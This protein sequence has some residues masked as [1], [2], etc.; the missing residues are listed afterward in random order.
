MNRR[1]KDPVCGMEVDPHDHALVYLQMH[2]AFC[3]LQCRERFLANPHLY[4]GIPGHPSPKQ[5]GME[6]VKRRHLRVAKP[7]SSDA[8]AM[9]VEALQTMMG[10]RAVHAE[11]DRVEIAYDLLQVT[12]EQIETKMAEVGVRLGEGWA[13]RLRRAFVNFEEETQVGSLT[14]NGKHCGK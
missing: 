7:L 14:G 2:F 8:A 12:H 3:S 5:E 9:L 13:E 4:V 10:I 11:G 6:I 1:V